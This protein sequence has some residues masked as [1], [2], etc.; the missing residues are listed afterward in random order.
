VGSDHESALRRMLAGSS[1]QA[2]PSLAEAKA[3]PEAAVVMEGDE[4]G[5]IYFTCPAR[6]V[7]CDEDAPGG[8]G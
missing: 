7:E 6:L 3:T 4:G 8:G 5:S 2:F 1:Y